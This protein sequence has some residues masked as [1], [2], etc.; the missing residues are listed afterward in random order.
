[1]KNSRMRG[2]LQISQRK[3]CYSAI[4]FLFRKRYEF[5]TCGNADVMPPREKRHPCHLPATP[6]WHRAD[7]SP[8]AATDDRKMKPRH[9]LPVDTEESVSSTVSAAQMI[10]GATVGT[11][12]IS[13]RAL[14]IKGY[15]SISLM[16]PRQFRGVARGEVG[17]IHLPNML[18][19]AEIP[20]YLPRCNRGVARGGSQG[21]FTSP[22][23]WWVPPCE[24]HYES[25]K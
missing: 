11:H 17:G 9:F 3:Y 20:S 13:A 22:I 12:A 24:L 6:E 4:P 5:A 23:C 19:G 7:I 16:C 25:S 8:S 2:L 21:V 10:G 1:M 18:V 14:N 15:S